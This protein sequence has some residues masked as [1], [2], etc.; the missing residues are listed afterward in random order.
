MYTNVTYCLQVRRSLC[1]GR[2]QIQ[3]APVSLVTKQWIKKFKKKEKCNDNDRERCVV[4]VYRA[5]DVNFI[6]KY[7]SEVGID[8]RK[9]EHKAR[10]TTTHNT[11]HVRND[12]NHKLL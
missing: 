4:T 5:S 10:I 6:D 1:R 2:K 7:F 11:C 9:F 8:I 12:N 3:Y